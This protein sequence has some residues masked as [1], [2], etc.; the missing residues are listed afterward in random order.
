LM[1]SLVENYLQLSWI[2][3]RKVING[4]NLLKFKKKI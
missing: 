3:T 4:I 1:K 2:E